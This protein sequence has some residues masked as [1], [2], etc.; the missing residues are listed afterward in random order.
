MH[1]PWT[2]NKVKQTCITGGEKEE[3][4]EEEKV[5]EDETYRRTKM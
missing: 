5:N 1:F 4:E 3:D 2:C